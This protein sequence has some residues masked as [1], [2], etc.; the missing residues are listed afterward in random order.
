[1]QLCRNLNGKTLL[2]R[3]HSRIS[4]TEF[5]GSIG[6]LTQV[7]LFFCIKMAEYLQVSQG[8]DDRCYAMQEFTS[9]CCHPDQFSFQG[10]FFEIWI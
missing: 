7:L 9:S 6:M 3:M 2:A 8:S 5:G 10:S 1:M 4:I